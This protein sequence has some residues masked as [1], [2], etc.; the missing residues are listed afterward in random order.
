MPIGSTNVSGL[1]ML[2]EAAGGTC[3]GSAYGSWSTLHDDISSTVTAETSTVLARPLSVTTTSVHIVKLS[4][5]VTR[6]LPRVK[7]LQGARVATTQAVVRF[8]GLYVP[9]PM[10]DV[11][12]QTF[13][14]DGTIRVIRLDNDDNVAAGL[15]MTVTNTGTESTSN[16]RDTTYRYSNVKPDR[17]GIDAKGA[18]HVLALVETAGVVSTGSGPLSLEMLALN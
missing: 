6:F 16:F 2:A 12:I 11:L 7:Y 14:D 13:P 15:I 9:E 4:A 1:K 3:P 8:Y 17:D 10:T 18:T 5:G